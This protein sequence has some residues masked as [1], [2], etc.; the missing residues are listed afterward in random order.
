[1]IFNRRVI[2]AHQ[3]PARHLAWPMPCPISPW[4]DST[5]GAAVRISMSVGVRGVVEGRLQTVTQKQADG[6]EVA[7]ELMTRQGV[8]HADLRVGANMGRR[9]AVEGQ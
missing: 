8:I 5:D 2:E 1:M 4:V 3:P 7:V 6:G 9:Q